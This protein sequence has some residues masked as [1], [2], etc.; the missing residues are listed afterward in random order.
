MPSYILE[1]IFS[2]GDGESTQ[3][4]QVQGST[5]EADPKELPNNRRYN[6]LC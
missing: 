4:H 2:G 6:S 3:P 5:Q 1:K